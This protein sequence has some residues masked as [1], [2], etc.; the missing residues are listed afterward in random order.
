MRPKTI[1]MTLMAILLIIILLEIIY[2]TNATI[3]FGS[4]SKKHMVLVAVVIAFILGYMAGRPGRRQ[5]FGH[6]HYD[7]I[8]DARPDTLSDEDRNYIS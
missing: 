2:S 6:V 7:E 1:I 3:I 4:V 5:K 8:D